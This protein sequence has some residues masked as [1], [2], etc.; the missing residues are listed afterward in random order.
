MEIN[1]LSSYLFQF[2][3]TL[4][5]SSFKIIYIFEGAIN[6]SFILVYNEHSFEKEFILFFTLEKFLG[7][8]RQKKFNVNS[9]MT[10]TAWKISHLEI[11]SKTVFNEKKKKNSSDF[12]RKP[13]LRE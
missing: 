10:N 7:N 8:F 12:K 11:K 13:S 3:I 2:Q 5:H 4:S 6:H 1:S 9:C